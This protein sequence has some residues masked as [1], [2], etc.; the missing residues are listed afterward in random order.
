M[1]VLHLGFVAVQAA[2]RKDPG[3]RKLLER[4]KVTCTALLE[5]CRAP[6]RKLH[7]WQSVTEHCSQQVSLLA[8]RLLPSTS[9]VSILELS[10][11][12][13]ALTS[14]CVCDA[15]HQTSIYIGTIEADRP[16][17]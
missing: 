3:Q 2:I 11:S 1:H 15:Q 14:I 7:G 5:Q 8:L 4:G 9:G 16:L 6:R 12:H 17:S 10:Q 13:E